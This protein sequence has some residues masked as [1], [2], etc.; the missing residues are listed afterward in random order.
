MSYFPPV[1]QKFRQQWW[2]PWGTFWRTQRRI[3]KPL[4]TQK[5]RFF[6]VYLTK[7]YSFK[8]KRVSLFL[9]CIYFQKIKTKKIF[10][11]KKFDASSSIFYVFSLPSLMKVM[12]AK[13]LRIMSA[14][15]SGP[16]T[17][18][19]TVSYHFKAFTIRLFFE[20]YRYR[21]RYFALVQL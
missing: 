17:Q 20:W 18:R 14:E 21:R 9:K 16:N 8:K 6:W 10:I 2:K 5:I 15:V 4:E 1:N 11:K 19:L 7:N 3:W 12:S 13:L